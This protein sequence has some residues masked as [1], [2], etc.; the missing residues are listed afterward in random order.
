MALSAVDV[1]LRDGSPAA[2]AI[3]GR[4]VNDQTFQEFLAAPN[5]MQYLTGETSIGAQ[6]QGASYELIGKYQ[7]ISDDMYNAKK[8]EFAKLGINLDAYIDPTIQLD[9]PGEGASSNRDFPI[10]HAAKVMKARDAAIKM[11]SSGQQPPD[12]KAK[13]KDMLA[14]AKSR[15]QMAWRNPEWAAAV[16]KIQ[17]L[18]DGLPINQGVAADVLK[19]QNAAAARAGSPLP[20]PDVGLPKDASAAQ[21]SISNVGTKS[22]PNAATIKEIQNKLASGVNAG[23]QPLSDVQRQSLLSQLS[24][25]G[26]SLPSG[27]NSTGGSSGL[28]SG[29][30]LSGNS[31]SPSNNSNQSALDIINNSDLDAGTKMLFNQIVKDWNPGDPVNVPNVISKFQEIAKNTIDPYFQEL[32]NTYI[33]QAQQAQGY[34]STAR[35]DEL[36]GEKINADESVRNMQGNLENRGM[37]FSGEAVRQL[38]NKSA[39]SNQ[40][41]MGNIPV[42]FGGEEGLVNKQNRLI[43]SSSSLRYKQNLNQLGQ[44]LESQLG[45]SKAGGLIPGA[46]LLGGVDQTASLPYQEK[47]QK[48]NVLSSLYDQ[49]KQNYQQSQPIK[50][51]SS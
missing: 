6:N 7:K 13:L 1:Y 35:K 32:S 16:Q 43:A 25:L 4:Q 39:Y 20:Y 46:E 48:G 26:G 45:S 30:T 28:P 31:S 12:Y 40:N 37:T 33:K 3:Y 15:Q 9:N 49:E 22:N 24:Q 34:L 44:Q 29:G 47:Q 19:A 42:Q 18:I 8:Q 21:S 5:P 51:F 10:E 36:E 17:N 27:V 38:G 23:G 14:E 50:P 41:Q 11:A 2:K